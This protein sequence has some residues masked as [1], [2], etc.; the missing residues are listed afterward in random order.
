MKLILPVCLYMVTF[1][2]GVYADDF[3]NQRRHMVYEI[4][5]MVNYTSEK[6][7]KDALDE[8]VMAAMAK[9]PR[10]EFV[11]DEM[12]SHAYINSALPIGLGQTISQPYIVAL[13]TDLAQV[14]QGSRVLEV[15]TGSGY[16]AAILAE[17]ADHV[18][19][20]EIVEPLGL[21]AQD[22]LQNL[23]YKNVSVRIGDGYH[24]WPEA[25]PF[26]AILVTAAVEEVPADLIQ[27]LEPGGRL[28]IPLGRPSG[29]QVLSVIRKTTDGSVQKDEVL[30]V[31]F[32]PL[33]GNHNIRQE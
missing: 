7:G 2:F 1:S 28:V 29:T 24:G 16:Q 20:I 4:N 21:Q 15:G 12:K 26:D 30:P 18:Y 17:L 25:A 27:Q 32:V 8:R 13:M 10:H 14:N 6:I 3:S 23:G 22:T 9:V 5:D 19:T 33:T 31:G 11:P